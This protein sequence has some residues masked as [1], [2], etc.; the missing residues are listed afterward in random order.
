MSFH[1]YQNEHPV[2][3]CREIKI[4]LVSLF[5]RSYM[6]AVLLLLSHLTLK[7]QVENE[8]EEESFPMEPT[9]FHLP[10]LGSSLGT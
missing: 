7:Q 1:F 9:S 5:P 3:D 10:L 2:I 8:A 4:S 6:D